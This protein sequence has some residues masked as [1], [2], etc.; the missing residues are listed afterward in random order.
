MTK[1]DALRVQLAEL[2]GKKGDRDKV[3]LVAAGDRDKREEE[4]RERLN[5]LRG[6]GRSWWQRFRPRRSSSTTTWF[7]PRAM[8]RWPRLRSWTAGTMSTTAGPAR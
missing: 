7:A 6:S 3:R 5:Q 1:A 8:R 4:I 2:D